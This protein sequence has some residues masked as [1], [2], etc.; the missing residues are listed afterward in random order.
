MTRSTARRRARPNRTAVPAAA[1]ATLVAAGCTGRGETDLPPGGQSAYLESPVAVE[2]VATGLVVPWALAFAPD[3]RMF[4]TERPGRI[5]MIGENGL[6]PEPWATLDVAATQEAGLL[7]IALA[8]DFPVSGQIFVAGTFVQGDRLVNRV[9]RLTESGGR[10]TK[11]TV[12]V[13]EIPAFGFHAGSALSFGADGFL[14]VTTGDARR[15]ELAQDPRSPAGKVLRVQAAGRPAPGN[16]DP[17]TRVWALGVRNPQGLA[18]H[19]E[20]DALFATDHGP[21]GAPNEGFRRNNDEVNVILRAANYGWPRAAGRRHQ[22]FLA[23]L[24]LWSPA[25]APS[26]LA[27]YDG[28]HA[29]WRGNLFVGTLRGQQL[30]RLVLASDPDGPLGWRVLSQ[31]ALLDKAVGRIRAVTMGPDG[32][33]YITTSNRE[34]RGSPSTLDDRVLR[35]IP[36]K[37]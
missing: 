20:T 21:S 25:L 13:D 27:F 7:G 5:R 32:Y 23:P 34:G 18:W 19:P 12:V 37:P 28:P 36:A 1:L 17:A 26:G 15:P 31:E 4:L 29:P 2:T 33:L 8:P 30:Q 10:G 35:V 16:P 6:E 14:Y 24:V 9:V 3:G 22:G 11:P